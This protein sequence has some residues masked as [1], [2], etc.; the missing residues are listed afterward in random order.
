MSDRNRIGVVG[1]GVMGAR[2][3]RVIAESSVKYRAE[4]AAICDRDEARAHALAADVGAA[5]YVD[6]ADML[7][8]E[9]LDAVYLA[10]PDALHKAPALQCIAA[11]VA[12]L[13][14]KP[15][16]TTTADAIE[17]VRAA[18]ASAKLVQVNFTNRWNPPF[19]AARAAIERGEIGDVIGINARLSNVKRI[20]KSMPWASQT[21]SGWFLLSHVFDVAGWLADT[22]ASSVFAGGPRGVLESMGID[23]YDILHAMVTYTSGAS[24]IYEAAWTL[25]DGMP[26][27]ADFKLQLIGSRGMIGIDTSNQM[28]V[29]SDE[30]Q[31]RHPGVLDWAANRFHSFLDDL[32][33]GR[34]DEH[35]LLAGLENT[36]LLVAMH[37]SAAS[38]LPVQLE[39]VAL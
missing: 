12:V 36:Q 5:S 37:E 18:Q 22:H 24:G 1:A 11:G 21:T 15:L 28:I 30:Q 2:Y 17:I 23:T 29:V 31:T 16:A 39:E 13:I 19:A 9:K 32:E 10:V 3:A 6:I 27:A 20:P 26:T 4:V 8:S 34:D 33:A 14:E 38:G 35:L 25:P 7:S